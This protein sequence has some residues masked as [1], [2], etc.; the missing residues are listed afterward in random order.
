MDPP[1]D[2]DRHDVEGYGFME[3]L[4][5]L[6]PVRVEPFADVLGLDTGPAG[7]FVEDKEV[8]ALFSLETLAA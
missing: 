1:G 4:G 6:A 7:L 5:D 3:K 2:Q 8:E